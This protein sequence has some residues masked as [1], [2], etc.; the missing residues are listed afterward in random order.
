[1]G[2]HELAGVISMNSHS[3]WKQFKR[4]T[5]MPPHQYL[6]QCLVEHAQK[7]LKYK[8]LPLTDI[9]LQCGFS[10]QSHLNRHFRKRLGMTPREFRDR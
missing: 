8:H 1:L 9:A 6:L 5:G 7:L 10:D 2:L 4:S 3:F